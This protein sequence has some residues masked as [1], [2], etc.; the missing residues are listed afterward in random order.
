NQPAPQGFGWTMK[1]WLPR[2]SFAGILPADR[3]LEQKL[4]KAYS[5]LVPLPQRK[6]YQETQMP[7]MDFRFFNG[8][9]EGLVLPFLSGSEAVKLANLD[10]EGNQEFQLPDDR[11]QLVVDIGKGVQEPQI[12]LHTVMIRMDDRQVDLLW[13][14]AV[15]YPG[16]DW[17]PKM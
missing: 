3:A 15:P 13:R 8:A 17:L 14:G 2:S 1:T 11:P 12:A 6:L 4:R 16:P 5:R 7:T 9:S 10:P